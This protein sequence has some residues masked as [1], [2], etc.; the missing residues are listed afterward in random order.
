MLITGHSALHT[1]SA[2]VHNAGEQHRACSWHNWARPVNHAHASVNRADRLRARAA[3]T[4]AELR[5]RLG[6]TSG[7]VTD[8]AVPEGHKGLHGFLYG[9]GGAEAH[10]SGSQYN[11]REGQDDGTSC[12]SVEEYLE[13]RDGERPLGVYALY[14]AHNNVQY[15]GYSRNMVIAVK[16]HLQRV[17]EAQCAF[18]RA[19]VFANAAMASRSNLEREMR[20]WIDRE[21]VVPPGNGPEKELWEGQAAAK[22]LSPAEM[23]EYEEKKLKMRK[24]MGE[25][26]HDDV[27][28]EAP[29]S[30]QRRLNLIKAVEGD[31]WSGVID[32]QTQQTIEDGVTSDTS[33]SD[34][35]TIARTTHQQ[36]DEAIRQ[37]NRQKAQQ[38]RAAASTNGQGSLSV[39]DHQRAAELADRQ[40]GPVTGEA[41][42]ETA[43]AERQRRLSQAQNEEDERA[44]L[45]EDS[46][47]R[48]QAVVS[49]FTK[50]T[51]HRQI[52]S[53]HDYD[54]D[55]EL[56]P[57]TPYL[58]DKALDE[59]RP[60]LIADGGNVEVVAVQDGVVMLRLQ[61]A[62]GTCPSST[63]TMK[64]GIERSLR[65]TFGEQ[66]LEVQQVDQIDTSASV[67]SVNGH[68]DMLRPAIQGYGGSVEVLAVDD[69]ICE[70]KYVGPAPIGMGIQAAIK[71]KFPDIRVVEL[72]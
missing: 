42:G 21:G 23:A 26:L 46:V 17:G 8:Q 25:N 62:C 47:Q 59:V 61:G 57:L 49:P 14:D 54:G 50:A 13:T 2:L 28:G 39:S 9:E 38:Q 53:S 72:L 20:S 40:T 35:E 70:L 31:D 52:G 63:A 3:P 67:A 22:V 58:V 68:L 29:D 36:Q 41:E 12:L 5:E 6:E 64:M 71:D 34:S 48:A 32:S 27:Q 37:G 55:E 43:E 1:K 16:N 56:P 18:V 60:Y 45:R 10:D 33:V 30:K 65:A 51:V 44:A 11:F 4:D 69:G 7:V 24:A 15:V 19:M 66:L